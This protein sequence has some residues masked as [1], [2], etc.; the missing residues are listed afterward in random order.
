VGFAVDKVALWQVSSEYFGIAYQFS[1]H[2][3]LHHHHLSSCGGTI[4][5]TVA[6]V[7]SGFSLTPPQEI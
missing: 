4:S 6:E 7:P 5:Q 1:F 2:Q 3:L